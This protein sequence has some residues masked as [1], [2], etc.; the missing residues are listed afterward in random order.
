MVP[1]ESR[2]EWYWHTECHRSEEILPYIDPHLTD[3]GEPD[4]CCIRGELDD[5]DS[6]DEIRLDEMIEFLDER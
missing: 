1:D 4:G 5:E 3:I 6:E 2:Y